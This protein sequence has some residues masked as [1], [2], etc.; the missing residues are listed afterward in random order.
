MADDEGLSR[1]A[2][3]R[4]GVAGTAGAI[5]LGCGPEAGTDAGALDDAGGLDAGAVEDAGAE[6]AGVADAGPPP[7][8]LAIPP[9]KPGEVVGG[10]RVHTLQMQNGVTELLPGL[11]TVTAGYDGSFLGPALELRRGEEVEIQVTN[12]LGRVTTT[13]WHGMHVPAAMD[14]GPHQPIADGETW[15][16]R[17]TVMNRASLCWFHPHAMGNPTEPHATSYQVYRGLA[18]LLWVRDDESDALALPS[19]YGVDD[20]PLV[21]QDRRFE[22]DGALFDFEPGAS[23][24][25]VRKGGDFFVNGV[26][27]P[28]LATHAQQVR[29][30]VLN[31]SNARLYHLAVLDDADADR[32]VQVI[33]SDGGLLGAPVPLRRVTLSPGERVEIVVDLT[34]DEGRTLR[35]VSKN[36]ELSI[37]QYVGRTTADAWDQQ[38]VHLMTL[39]VGP[40]TAGAVMSLPATLAPVARIPESDAVTTRVFQL[41]GPSGENHLINGQ[42]MDITRT[43]AEVPLGD[44]EIWEI[45]NATST[46]HPFHIHG[47]PFQVLS[48]ANIGTDGVPEHELGEKDTVLV[49]VGEIVR[50]IRRFTDFADPDGYY[51][52]HCHILEHEDRGMM[53][54]FKVV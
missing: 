11:S 12:D 17:F 43:D 53:G 8:R 3:L 46:A 54:Q 5:V 27:T 48:R 44:T 13:H 30:R 32:E 24:H 33:A 51:M 10:V 37:D 4:V 39:E 50:V 42:A 15:T 14:G 47:A 9:L 22:P 31:G 2:F 7:A 34:G 6:D 1:R 16:A 40:P 20:I 19:T 26:L 45:Q 23:A 35:L 41:G 52:F 38:T 28:G 25:A 49:R 18:G 29:F 36:E 21:L